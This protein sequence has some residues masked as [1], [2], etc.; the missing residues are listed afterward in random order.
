MKAAPITEIEP[1][2]R[3]LKIGSVVH[4]YVHTRIT[5]KGMNHVR[6]P[7]YQCSLCPKPG[8]CSNPV[9]RTSDKMHPHVLKHDEKDQKRYE[10]EMAKVCGMSKPIPGQLG[11]FG[12]ADEVKK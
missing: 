3:D 6:E 11:I 4:W 12:L 1:G 5:A 9:L 8:P 7:L 2:H 10:R